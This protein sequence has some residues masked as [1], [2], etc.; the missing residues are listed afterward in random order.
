MTANGRVLESA[1]RKWSSS[2]LA[3]VRE[4]GESVKTAARGEIPT[5][6]KYAEPSPYLIE[7]SAELAS[8]VGQH[9]VET[10][11]GDWC[12]LVDHDPHGEK[13]ILTSALYRFGDM[14]YI[15]SARV[16]DTA[17]LETL[18]EILLKRLG[19][20]DIPMREL[21]H[22]SYTFDLLMDQGA[23]AEFKRH[24]MM[25]Q[26]AQRLSCAHGYAVPRRFVV[27]G[28]EG[29]YR[30]AME[31]AARFWHKLSAWN[32]EV[33]QYV[34]PN[35]FNR[36]VLATFN[37]REAYSFC[38]LRA[39]ANAH[40]S[41]RRIAQRVA[42]EISRVHPLLARQMKLHNETWQGIDTENFVP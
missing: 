38:Q 36:R 40:F 3:E 17:G 39:A 29:E 5:L 25:T 7:T 19:R 16:V 32:P 10:Q 33:A 21:E 6:V 11:P 14:S 26:S 23:Y 37:L 8:Y 15:E 13:R 2:P 42:Q 24:R 31:T 18:A 4:I 41:I 20:H 12:V 30:R 22:S 35:G 1:I 27:A 28:F 9:G 34:V